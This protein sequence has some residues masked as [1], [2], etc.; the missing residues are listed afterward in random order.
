MAGSKALHG[1]YCWQLNVIMDSLNV[2]QGGK[3]RWVHAFSNV[4]YVCYIKVTMNNIYGM[5]WLALLFF[6]PLYI[7][8][9]CPTPD[10][11]Y[12]PGRAHLLHGW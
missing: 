4:I 11:S 3:E 9:I 7:S 1:V 8:D 2:K 5:C 6:S 12:F 10:G